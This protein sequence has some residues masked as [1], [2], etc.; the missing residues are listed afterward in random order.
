MCVDACVCNK[1]RERE[2]MCVCLSVRD[3]ILQCTCVIY[4]YG[5]YSFLMYVY[6][7]SHL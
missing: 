3:S 1:E 5:A 2:R 7:L 4:T 6:G